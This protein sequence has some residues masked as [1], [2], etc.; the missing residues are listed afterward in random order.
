MSSKGKTGALG[1]GAFMAKG[2]GLAAP[3]QGLRRAPAVL[4]QLRASTDSGHGKDVADAE[5]GRMR[6]RFFCSVR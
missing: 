6:G 2:G 3:M 1:E 4:S 5:V